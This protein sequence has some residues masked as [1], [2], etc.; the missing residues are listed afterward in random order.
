MLRASDLAHCRD[1][2]GRKILFRDWDIDDNASISPDVEEVLK[3]GLDQDGIAEIGHRGYLGGQRHDLHEV[4][5]QRFI[6]EME[7]S[8]LLDRDQN[9]IFMSL[10]NVCHAGCNISCKGLVVLDLA[11]SATP[12][13]QRGSS[14][15]GIYL[16][17]NHHYGI[18]VHPCLGHVIHRASGEG[19]LVMLGLRLVDFALVGASM[20][21]VDRAGT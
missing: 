19:L 8:I 20:F 1:S 2:V 7:T 6:S 15:F 13:N 14:Y 3:S 12:H 9:V 4:C 10:V 16:D 21:H 5:W 11:G 18:L 17:L